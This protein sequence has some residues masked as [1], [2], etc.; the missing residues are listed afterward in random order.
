MSN[1]Y[2]EIDLYEK[3]FGADTHGLQI[4]TDYKVGFNLLGLSAYVAIGLLHLG[5]LEVEQELPDIY[6]Q[7]H[8]LVQG[9]KIPSRGVDRIWEI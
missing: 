3:G 5:D 7:A 8:K 6:K 2:R 4:A 9:P 1:L